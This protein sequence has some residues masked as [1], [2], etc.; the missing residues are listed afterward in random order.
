MRVQRRRSAEAFALQV[1]TLHTLAT[2]TDHRFHRTRC[3]YPAF[4]NFFLLYRVAVALFRLSLLAR[5]IFSAHFRFLI[6]NSGFFWRRANFPPAFSDFFWS[7]QAPRS[8]FPIFLDYT[9]LLFHYFGFFICRR[10]GIAG[11]RLARPRPVTYRTFD[12]SLRQRR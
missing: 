12:P 2:I 10:F 3:V 5:S 11:P 7:E 6:R 9:A 4:L 1:L 8:L